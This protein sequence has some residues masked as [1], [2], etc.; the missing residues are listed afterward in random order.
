MNDYGLQ[1]TDPEITYITA[2]AAVPAG[3]TADPATVRAWVR[4]TCGAHPTFTEL[5]AG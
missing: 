2:I 3:A 5:T 4:P 1:V